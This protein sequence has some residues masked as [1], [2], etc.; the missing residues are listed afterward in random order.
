MDNWRKSRY[1]NS[2]GNCVEAANWRKA[3]ASLAN[4][5]CVEAGDAAGGVAVRDTTDR[6][7]PQL[8]FSAAAWSAFLGG[9]R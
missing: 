9:L 4:Q 6:T 8:A 3:H 7:G 1:S 5:G 2:Q